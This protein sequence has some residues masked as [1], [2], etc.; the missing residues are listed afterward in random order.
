MS[1]ANGEDAEGRFVLRQEA[2][3][4]YMKGEVFCL[5]VN[6]ADASIGGLIVESANA[7]LIGAT[8]FQ[9]IR[10][11]GQGR[12]DNDQSQTILSLNADPASCANY[13]GFDPAFTMDRGQ[14]EVKD[15]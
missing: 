13:L 10:D 4:V 3:S 6:G 9:I 11:N 8:F 5:A 7:N 15:R 2:G 1:G 14:Y 12:D